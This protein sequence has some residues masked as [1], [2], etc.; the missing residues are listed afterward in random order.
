[1]TKWEGLSP[2]TVVL[3]GSN[4]DTILKG[5]EAKRRSSFACGGAPSQAGGVRLARLFI[6][7]A[8]NLR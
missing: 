6:G 8:A 2:L 4:F 3:Q 5:C 7:S 1:M